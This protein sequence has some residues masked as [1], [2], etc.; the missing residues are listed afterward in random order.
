MNLIKNKVKRSVKS[1]VVLV[2]ALL[3]SVAIFFQTKL[4][5][6][7]T[8]SNSYASSRNVDLPS[9]PEFQLQDKTNTLTRRQHNSLLLDDYDPSRFPVLDTID[10]A[11]L[12]IKVGIVTIFPL[13]GEAMHFL[14]DGVDQSKVFHLVGV[15]SLY[16]GTT[17]NNNNNKTDAITIIPERGVT[18]QPEDA[19]LWIVDGTRVAKLRRPFL[20]RLVQSSDAPWTVLFV[21]FTDRFHNQ[22]Q[23]YQK[24]NIWDDGRGKKK[25]VRIAARSIVHGRHFD[26]EKNRIVPGR[27]APNLR[28][29]GGPML[30]SPYAV[31]SDIIDSIRQVLQVSENSTAALAKAI[32]DPDRERS[33][34]VLHLWNISFVEGRSKLRNAVS[35]LVRSW[36]GFLKLEGR[37][38]T[39]SIEEQGMRRH[40][41]RNQVDLSYIRA[42]LSAKIVIVTQKDDWEDHY[43][44]FES[45]SCGSLILHDAMVAPPKGLVQDETVVFFDSL[46]SLQG[47]VVHYLNNEAERNAVSRKGWEVA[48]GQHR[49][50][51]RMEELVF[52]RPVSSSDLTESVTD[53]FN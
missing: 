15:V 4:N 45:V 44:L 40:V 1:P 2:T 11:K 22:F 32:F 43:R 27:V 17:T 26:A 14:Y 9:R 39:T 8:S 51:H 10:V 29:G 41:G 35:K 20:D 5:L 36:N 42:L 16:G 52:G 53:R 47:R 23:N 33:I 50:W 21:D 25:H 13:N 46:D 12:P 37:Y 7:A 19:N 24:L 30:H 34:D 31:R 6:Q 38:A 49:S 3:I 18:L 48:M 28:T